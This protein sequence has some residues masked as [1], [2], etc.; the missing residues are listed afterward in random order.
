VTPAKEAVSN[1]SRLTE[2]VRPARGCVKE[3]DRF[4]RVLDIT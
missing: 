2:R 4:A 3:I 1:P